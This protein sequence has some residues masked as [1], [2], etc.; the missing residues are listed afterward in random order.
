MAEGMTVCPRFVTAV[1]I[2]HLRYATYTRHYQ[3]MQVL[4][5]LLAQSKTSLTYKIAF[6]NVTPR[7]NQYMPNPLNGLLS[8]HPRITGSDMADRRIENRVHENREIVQ[9]DERNN[10]KNKESL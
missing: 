2:I 5:T 1:C 8:F 10:A 7:N 3:K 4:V 9:S 6:P